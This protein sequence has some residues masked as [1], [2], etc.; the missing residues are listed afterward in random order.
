MYLIFYIVFF[1]RGARGRGVCA[2]AC[3]RIIIYLFRNNIK[4][5]AIE[6]KNYYLIFALF[7]RECFACS[8][9]FFFL[10]FWN[11]K[12]NRRRK[13]KKKKK[14]SPAVRSPQADCWCLLSEP[15]LLSPLSPPLTPPPTMWCCRSW[16]HSIQCNLSACPH[17]SSPSASS[18]A[19]MLW[20]SGQT[21]IDEVF[22]VCVLG[23]FFLLLLHSLV[24]TMGTL[25]LAETV[26]II[27]Y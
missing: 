16:L 27:H 14:T 19:L 23:F 17:S 26:W 3:D 6:K 24:W 5:N 13:R 9:D 21:A 20:S 22:W 4:K 12:V 18:P 10:F 15:E 7:W 2:R 11:T 8:C 1:W 25:S